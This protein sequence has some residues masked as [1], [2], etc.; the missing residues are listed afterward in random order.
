MYMRFQFPTCSGHDHLL[1]SGSKQECQL[2]SWNTQLY[3]IRFDQLYQVICVAI[4]IIIII[5]Y[6]A[7]NTTII[8]INTW[9]MNKILYK[10]LNM[11]GYKWI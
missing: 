8:K 7:K 2:A 5:S 1:L 9:E 3:Q 6:S 11:T 4:I 10:L